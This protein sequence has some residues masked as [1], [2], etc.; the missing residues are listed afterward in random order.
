MQLAEAMV[1][2]GVLWP[3]WHKA[4]DSRSRLFPVGAIDGRVIGTGE[5]GWVT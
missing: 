5:L 4:H 3:S 2:I 1:Q